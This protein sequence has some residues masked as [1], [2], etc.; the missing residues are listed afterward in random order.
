VG[1]AATLD[2]MSVGIASVRY[3]GTFVGGREERGIGRG[4]GSGKGARLLGE[5]ANLKFRG[6]GLGFR[7]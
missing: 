5:G 2:C 7:V 1:V 3:F 6:W 4:H